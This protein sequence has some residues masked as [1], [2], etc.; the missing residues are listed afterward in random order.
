M[1]LSERAPVDDITF[2]SFIS[3]PG[4]EVGDEPVAKTMFLVFYDVFLSSL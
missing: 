2:F 3:I 1:L 4:R